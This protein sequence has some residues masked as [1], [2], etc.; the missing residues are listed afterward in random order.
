MRFYDWKMDAIKDGRGYH[1]DIGA[2]STGVTGGGNGT[3][4]DQ[5]QPEGIVSVPTGTSI[6]P[7]RID[8]TIQVPLLVADSEENE[9]LAAVDVAA[10]AA[11]TTGIAGATAETP[12][13]MKKGHTNTSLCSCYSASEANWTNPTL[14]MELIRTTITG[15]VQ[16]T[17]GV[18][19]TPHKLLFIPTFP[20]IL[21]G[22]CALYIYWGGT[23]AQTGFAQIEWLE[24]PT[25]Y[26][27]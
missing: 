23:V 19:W 11:G 18:M 8:V 5:D 25:T 14:G 12:V 20:P 24:Y 16:S 2:F 15:D 10:E 27:R 6:I 22:P 9:I 7:I 17:A 1:M 26:F 13:N 3:V 21:D 4:M